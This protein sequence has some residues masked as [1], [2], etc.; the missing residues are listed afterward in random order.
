MLQFLLKRQ[1]SFLTLLGTVHVHAD[2][3]AKNWTKSE[4]KYD[5]LTKEASHL[6]VELHSDCV[7]AAGLGLKQDSV[8]QLIIVKC[9]S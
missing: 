2:R 6:G 7:R 1:N 5:A 9:T 8:S 4:V 3:S